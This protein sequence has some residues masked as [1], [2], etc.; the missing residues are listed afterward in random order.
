MEVEARHRVFKAKAK[1]E[2]PISN[3]ECPMMKVKNKYEYT[4]FNKECLTL[5]L[6]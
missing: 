2:C 6:P 5:R 4:I 3:K 1:D